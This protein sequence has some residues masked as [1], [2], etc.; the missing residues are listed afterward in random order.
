MKCFTVLCSDD[1]IRHACAVTL[2]AI[3]RRSADVTRAHG[4][5]AL[6][7][8]F[9]GMHQKPPT[10]GGGSGEATGDTTAAVWEEVWQVYFYSS[11]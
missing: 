5:L 10:D 2:Q 4:A 6:P 1:G 9:L 3:T 11:H 7:L 8:A